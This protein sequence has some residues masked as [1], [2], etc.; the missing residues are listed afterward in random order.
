MNRGL[1]A[2]IFLLVAAVAGFAGYYFNRSSLSG[3]AS[4][5]AGQ[6]LLQAPFADLSGKTQ[7]LAQRRGRVLVVNFWATWCAP[8]REEIPALMRIHRKYASNGVELVGIALDDASKVQAYS[9]E[10]SMD[11][12]LLVAG[13]QT[14]ALGRDLGNQAGVLPYTVVLDRAGQVVYT[15]AGAMT[16]AMLEPVLRPLL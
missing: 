9:K 1:Q 12:A 13:A 14:L 10:M 11:Y 8:C 2:A 16:E 4:A 7:T 5:N 15:H 3:P 6:K